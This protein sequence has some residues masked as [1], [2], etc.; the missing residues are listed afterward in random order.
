MISA[1]MVTSRAVVASSA[2]I[3]RGSQEIAMAIMTRCSMPPDSSAGIWWKTSSGLRRPTAVNSSSV[4]AWAARRAS[5]CLTRSTSASWL[6][7]VSDGVRYEEGSWKTAPMPVPC[8]RCQPRGDNWVT[9]CRSNEIVPRS[10]PQPFGS[11]PRAARQVSVLPLPDSP[12]RPTISPVCTDSEM[13]RTAVAAPS[14]TVMF[15]SSMPRTSSGG[16]LPVT[17]GLQNLEGGMGL[18]HR[19]GGRRRVPA[20]RSRKA[21]ASALSAPTVIAISAPGMNGAHGA[22]DR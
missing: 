16:G 8:S 5:F 13:P 12:T 14:C 20:V 4:L 10:M 19:V 11:T 6:P 21:S 2:T 22:W 17:G 9:S 15:R 7:T 3:S 18:D 1:W